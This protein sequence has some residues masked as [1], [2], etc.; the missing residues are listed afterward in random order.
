MSDT[1]YD[2]LSAQHSED[3][4]PSV[5][6]EQAK[7]VA[8]DVKESGAQ[9]AGTAK[10]ETIQVATEA[11]E[12]AKDLFYQVRGEMS[13]Q[14][15]A[16]QHRAAGGLRTLADELAGMAQN[17]E[18]SGVAS[19]LA[20]QASQRV[21]TV[22]GWMEEREP[23]DLVAE[24][25]GFA[26]RKPGTFLAAAGAAV[27][28]AGRVSRG[29][30]GGQK[31]ASHAGG[32]AREGSRDGGGPAQ[33]NG[34]ETMPLGYGDGMPPEMPA[35]GANGDRGVPPEAPTVTGTSHGEPVTYT[36]G[37]IGGTA[38]SSPPEYSA[39]PGGF[40]DEVASDDP[41]S[42]QHREPGLGDPRTTEDEPR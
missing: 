19:D 30:T 22:A 8:S 16:Q 33:T 32:Q 14:T 31:D 17:S 4:T 39:E 5:A 12:Q 40:R 21:R 15:S 2:N 10:D 35:L 13:E 41:T 27:S 9:V 7:G 23:G 20:R 42:R 11:K 6:A 3:S 36:T 28:P 1:T 26:R 18:Q 25:K 34:S 37:S 29:G 24:L 38:M